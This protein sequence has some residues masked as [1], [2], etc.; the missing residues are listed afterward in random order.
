MP[1]RMSFLGSSPLTR[2][3]FSCMV[4]MMGEALVRNDRQYKNIDAW[5]QVELNV[6]GFVWNQLEDR[7]GERTIVEL[8]C[9]MEE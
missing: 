8:C 2:L 7:A 3:Y 9:P 1:T 4:G 6:S 5:T